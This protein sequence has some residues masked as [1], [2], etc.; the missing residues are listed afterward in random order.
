VLEFGADAVA[1]VDIANRRVVDRFP[2]GDGPSGAAYDPV[3]QV[4]YVSL[5]RDNA[6]AVVDLDPASPRYRQTVAKIAGE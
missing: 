5:F 1:V 3:A 6:V 4:L 2:V